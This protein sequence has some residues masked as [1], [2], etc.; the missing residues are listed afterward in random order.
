MDDI[1]NSINTALIRI[2]GAYAPNTLRSYYADVRS[3]VDW[4][5]ERKVEP[6]PLT[7]ETLCYFIE[8]LQ[9]DYS[10]SSIQADLG[11]AQIKQA[12]GI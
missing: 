6:F 11:A 12:I 1:Y 7:S 3:F 5:G 10:Y 8:S 4:C 2:Q 9:L